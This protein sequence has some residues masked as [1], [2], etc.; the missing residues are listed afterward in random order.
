M[1]AAVLYQAGAPLVVEEVELQ[2]PGPNEVLVRM[3][4]C[5]VCHSDLHIIRG[6]W[7]GFDPPIVVGHEGAGIVERVGEG[8]TAVA[9]GDHVVVGWKSRCGECRYCI[10]GRPHLC[11]RPP[12]LDEESS[13]TKAGLKVGRM[14]TSAFFAEYAV[15]PKSVAIPIREEVPLDRAALLGC[16][17][18]TG[19]G[20]AANTAQVKPGTTAAVYGCGGVGVNVIQGA[21]LCGA[22]QVIGVD[23]ADDKLEYAQGFGLTDVVNAADEDPATAIL[24]LTGGVGVDY[25]FDAVGNAKVMEQVF[26][27]LAKTGVAVIVGMPAFRETTRVSLPFMPFYGERWVTGSY[28]GGAVLWRDIPRLADLY[29]AGRLDLDRLVTRRYPLEEINEAFADLAGGKPG[30][31][32]ILF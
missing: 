27:S 19:V 5:G 29:L 16:A 22:A 8:V 1:R 2:G 10:T 20:A 26:A 12:L 4:A 21:A 6:E 7:A 31:G 13:I 32:T 17:V 23:I 9:P 25:G 24:D 28:Y 14:L 18:M 30:R 11:D 3:A 15:V